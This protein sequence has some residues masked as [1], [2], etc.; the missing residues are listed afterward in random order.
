MDG[1]TDVKEL[2]ATPAEFNLGQNYP[3]PFNPS[4]TI[5]FALPADMNVKLDVYNT[6][7]EKV[8]ELVNGQMSAGTYSIAFDA[9]SL[10][11]G[12]YFYR[13]E[14]GSNVAVRKMILMK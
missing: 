1:A 4:T 14:A 7:G 2:A 11:S 3:N 10:P 13:I 12:I 6:L 5:K 8:A 9:S